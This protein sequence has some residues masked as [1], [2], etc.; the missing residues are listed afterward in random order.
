[1][2]IDENLIDPEL[3]EVNLLGRLLPS[4]FSRKKCKYANWLLHKMSAGKCED[5]EITY[6]QHWISRKDGGKLRICIYK[7]KEVKKDVP[8]LLWIHGGG[9]ALGIP[10]MD[11]PFMKQF[12]L[13]SNCVIVSPDYRCSVDEPYPAALEDC[14]AALLWMKHNAEPLGIRSNQLDSRRRKCWRR[15]N[16]SINFVCT[17]QRKCRCSFSDATL[18]YDR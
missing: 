3:R 12:I 2:K 18:S 7:P 9:Y 13:D 11:L 5:E 14:Y 6:E 15:I 16:S 1:M 17:R 8:G 10:E 4:I